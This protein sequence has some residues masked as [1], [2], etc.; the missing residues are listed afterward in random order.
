MGIPM[1]FVRVDPNQHVCVAATYTKGLSSLM[2][3][4]TLRL[5][6]LLLIYKSLGSFES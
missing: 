1:M 5:K 2:I 4:R 3:R 6:F